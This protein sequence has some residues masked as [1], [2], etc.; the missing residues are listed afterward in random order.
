MT[1][2]DL[3]IEAVLWG[4]EK[5]KW[6]AFRMVVTNFLRNK[7]ADS[8]EILNKPLYSSENMGCNLSICQ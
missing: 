2:M 6:K 4:K 1:W 3:E 5:E 8:P 7:S